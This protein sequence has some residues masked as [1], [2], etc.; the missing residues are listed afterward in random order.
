MGLSDGSRLLCTRL[1][2][3]GQSL[4]IT[5]FGQTLTATPSA[6]VF[7]QPLGDRAVYLSDLKPAEYHQT[8]YLDLSWPYQT[9]R[10]VTGG[11]L[12]CGG[13][14]Y[15]K[16]IGVH[17]AA[18]LVYTISPLP[19][20][21]EEQGVRGEGQGVRTRRFEAELGIDDSTG[22]RGSV[23][24]RVL[25]DGREKFASPIVRGGDAPLPI[26]VDVTDAQKLELVVDYAD[27]AEVLDHA[28]WLNARLIQ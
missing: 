8:P 28:N 1:L 11:L 22:G 15:L 14:L 23:Q 9:D 6:L 21:K 25:V 5:A 3:D 17:S 26:S 4:R 27:R 20:A 10:N 19:Q 7:L 16:G 18:R 13:R 24:F 12:R 2:M